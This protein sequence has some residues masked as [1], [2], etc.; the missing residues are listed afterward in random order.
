MLE[1]VMKALRGS[2]GIPLC[3]VGVDGQC[4]ALAILPQE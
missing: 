3:W 4:Y 2:R 1:Q